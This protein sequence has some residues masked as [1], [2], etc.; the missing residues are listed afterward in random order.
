VG[1]FSAPSVC[2]DITSVDNI[3]YIADASSGLIIIDASDP[4]NPVQLGSYN[5]PAAKVCVVDSVAYIENGCDLTIISVS[6][7]TNPTLLGTY[8]FQ[9]YQH[10]INDIV[11]R[12]NIIYLL[13]TS[14]LE[15]IDALI[16]QIPQYAGFYAISGSVSMDVKNNLAY[17]L[18][19]NYL[20][21][22]DVSD[23]EHPVQMS[24]W[25]V[26]QYNG[27]YSQID[28]IGNYAYIAI[29]Y[30]Y[31]IADISN[32]QMPYW[33]NNF[34]VL[35]LGHFT[36]HEQ[37]LYIYNRPWGNATISVYDATN[38]IHLT[39]LACYNCQVAFL[40]FCGSTLC[41]TSGQYLRLFDVSNLEDP[42]Y[43]G[44]YISGYPHSITLT[45][46]LAYCED[47]SY[48]NNIS[49][50]DISNINNPTY[51]ATIN[52][53]Y[54]EIESIQVVGNKCYI[55]W[56][57]TYDNWYDVIYYYGYR[58]ADMT[59]P[60][61]P[62]IEYSYI[63]PVNTSCR[64]YVSGSYLYM[65]EGPWFKV[66][67][68]SNPLSPLLLGSTQ[69]GEIY[70]HKITVLDT[71]ALIQHNSKLIIVNISNPYNPYLM[72]SYL[73]PT[74]YYPF[75]QKTFC[76]QNQ[77]AY[78]IMSQSSIGIVDFSNPSNPFLLNTINFPPSS[79]L[80]CIYVKDN[81]LFAAD[82]GWNEISIYDITN[83]HN[84]CYLGKFT[85][86]LKTSDIAYKDGYLFTVNNNHGCNIIELSSV[87][88]ESVPV[89]PISN[90]TLENYPNPF[91]PETTIKYS[92]P[93]AGRVDIE[94]YNSR[95]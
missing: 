42:V 63:G 17:I 70:G 48:N 52:T 78:C 33:I 30:K 56:H 19:G 57:Y 43:V 40:S 49:I 11:V 46:E 90:L 1:C 38:P 74:D 44:S 13:T 91:N 31:I 41:C 72:G 35:G 82:N 23:P 47:S 21:I 50:L 5:T 7:P 89:Y 93:A 9:G 54:D 95:G 15:I 22:I 94:I 61:N 8:Q 3:L 88:N 51:L 83:P 28:V 27:R 77:Y 62:S 58:I 4:S 34:D 45:N 29:A 14:G 55:G 86:N 67:D 84:L 26:D 16:P 79:S 6:N 18:D 71:I 85:Y 80:D 12:G 73:Y 60:S 32:P 37:K 64:L 2:S 76:T 24:N 87:H 75:S 68:N 92:I 81:L 53:D 69:F 10:W 36:V 39:K 59:N 66:F 25:Y 65:I 20:K